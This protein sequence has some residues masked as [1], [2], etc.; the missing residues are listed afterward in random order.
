[1]ASLARPTNPAV[2]GQTPC[3]PPLA[4]HLSSSLE[5]TAWRCEYPYE[6][7]YLELGGNRLHYLDEKPSVGIDRG[8]SNNADPVL[9]V[10]GNPTWSFYYRRLI[11]SLSEQ[12]RV[13]AVDNMG[14]GLSD[15]PADF[16]YCLQSHIDNVCAVVDQLGLQNVTLMA[17]D[18][19][20][21]I[22]MGAL[23]ARKSAFKKIILFNTAAFPPPYLPFRISVCRWPLIGKIGVQGFNMFA[24]AA[25]FMAT[26]QKGGLP[27]PIAAGLLAPYDSWANRVAIYQFVKDIPMSRT[28]RT[29]SVLETIENKLSTIA[30][31]PIQLIWG[32]KDW[33]FRPE[34]LRRFEENWPEAESH[35]LADAGHYVIEDEPE[36]VDRLVRE[37]LDR[38]ES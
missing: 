32:M 26:E 14:C 9:M 38:H 33:C 11:G 13:I 5:A 2:P 4:S 37:F 16:D 18:W 31:W 22:G 1:M 15:K 6:S 29:W 28:H 24:R 35:E 36:E 3:K 34:C 21:A 17:H 30:D 27:R 10:H 25:T 23:L 12:R 20:G 19:G 8:V 7:H